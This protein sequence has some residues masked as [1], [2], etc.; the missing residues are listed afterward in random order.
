MSTQKKVPL[1]P[2]EFYRQRRPEY[3]S[4]S[5]PVESITL[6]RELLAYE[7]DKITANQKESNFETLCRKLAEK[8]I[9]PNLVPQV[10]PTGGGDGKTDTETHPVSDTIAERWFI[11]ENGWSR[12]EKWAFAISA[13]EEW[14]SKCKSDVK[15]I[16]ETGR[17]YTRIY[18]M[19][20]RMISSKQKKD[21]QDELI[22]LHSIDVV[23]LDAEWI[24]EKVYSNNLQDIA[25][26]ALAL[27]AL[28][29]S[30]EVQHGP[31]D[32]ARLASLAELEEKIASPNRYSEYDHQLVEDAFEAA[33]LSRMLEK[34]REEVEGKFQRAIRFGIKLKDA[35]LLSRLYYQRCWTA[36][37]WYDDYE[38]FSTA[39]KLFKE[40]LDIDSSIAQAEHYQNLYNILSSVHHLFDFDTQGIDLAAEE[41]QL[42]E[43]L[44]RME[45]DH[46]KPVTALMA[47][48]MRAIHHL[49]IVKKQHQSPDHHL[50]TLIDCINS[51]G[52]MLN[53]PFEAYQKSIEVLGDGLA[54]NPVYDRL[55]DALAGV[56]EKRSSELSAGHVF[57][58]RA[59]QKKEAKLYSDGI[60]YFGK[61]VMKVAKQESTD[62]LYAALV[63]LSG[64]YR[65][66]GLYWAA[67]CCNIASCG[68]SF[69]SWFHSHSV[70]IKAYPSVARLAQAELMRGRLPVFLNWYELLGVLS[71]MVDLSEYEE[72]GEPTESIMNDGFLCCR[73]LNSDNS[74]MPKNLPDLL[75]KQ[76]VLM[77]SDVARY[78]LGY[79]E[80]VIKDMGKFA[81]D[82]KELDEYYRK[83][84]DQPF[85]HQMIE[86]TD[87]LDGE[88]CILSSKILGCEIFLY[89]PAD[90]DLYIIAEMLLGFM[91]AFMATWLSGAY[92][93]RE[94]I[95]VYLQPGLATTFLVVT[96]KAD[97]KGYDVSINASAFDESKHAENWEAIVNF[98]SMLLHQNFH[99]DK[100]TERI[101]NLFKEEE[102]DQR[103]ALLFEHRKFVGQVLGKDP[104]LFYKDFVQGKELKAYPSK[105]TEAVV[106]NYT[107]PDQSTASEVN[108]EKRSGPP[109]DKKVGHHKR[110]VS[111]IINDQFWDAAHW[112]GFGFGS[113]PGEPPLIF[114]AYENPEEGK[115]VFKEWIEQ[116]GRED[117]EERIHIT[118]IRGIEKEEPHWYRVVIYS[119]QD[120][121][122][123]RENEL[124]IV[125]ARMHTMN[126]DTSTNLE[127]LIRLF[128]EY[129]EYFLIPAA[130]HPTTHQV[131]P[132]TDLRIR[133]R[134]LYIRNAWEIG[135][136]DI[137][138]MGVF[139]ND[140]PIIPE[141]IE[142]APVLK[143]M[144]RKKQMGKH[145]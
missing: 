85:R 47:K 27:S 131:I 125:A 91:E 101:E 123:M 79:T 142:D 11:P 106:F 69:H 132:F 64:C 56:S 70:D 17:G 23:I 140:N 73:L 35:T 92:P 102:I 111:S 136:H 130:I 76:Q 44:A 49:F 104:K 116:L 22:K 18:F 41:K 24:L 4:D 135:S 107:T 68:L 54:N 95:N 15:K 42:D 77:A 53:Y 63:G 145:G 78:M 82:E 110:R 74:K 118:I 128:E 112:K 51:C 84:A 9:S 122:Q 57:L 121:G 19:S 38:G 2:S 71:G 98:M 115:K 60:I 109:D 12:D 81:K 67:H 13:K 113:A 100:L 127:T 1:S 83:V 28:Y 5:I 40:Q 25:I 133:K 10:G 138:I 108:P 6:P 86:P 34:P 29:K 66:M 93:A 8:T 20:S 126:A 141:G 45:A 144:E 134:S 114:I 50:Q 103:M 16:V 14:K 59:I 61:A 72:P 137:D 21:C 120:H 87:Y 65:Q 89:T 62:Y 99:F 129:E 39:F 143:A 117:T 88:Q 26:D 7:L 52:G 124:L 33:I 3:F 105:R 46:S 58:N 80:E 32:T 31:N 48:T 90:K 30:K 94:R 43:M 36:I 55:I 97:T 37:H 139:N 75:E 96:Q 119:E